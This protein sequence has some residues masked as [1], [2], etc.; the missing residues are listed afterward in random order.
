MHGLKPLKEKQI[1]ALEAFTS[2]YDMFVALPTGYGKSI[3]FGMLP[4]LFDKLLQGGVTPAAVQQW[5][6]SAMTSKTKNGS[7]S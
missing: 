6:L 2:G 4:L 5:T 1:E 3:I 7:F